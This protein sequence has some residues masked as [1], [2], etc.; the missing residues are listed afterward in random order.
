MLYGLLYFVSRSGEDEGLKRGAKGL[1][2][3]RSINVV[4]NGA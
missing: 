2:E 4:S 1:L 3:G